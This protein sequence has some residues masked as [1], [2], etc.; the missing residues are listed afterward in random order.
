MSKNKN[1]G[2]RFESALVTL[3]NAYGLNTRRIA[4]G[5]IYDRGD[6]EIK[7]KYGGPGGEPIV[8]LAWKR[9]VN[10]GGGKRMPDGEPVVVVL[11]LHDF[12]SLLGLAEVSAVIE[13]KAAERL[14][15]TRSL[16]KAIVK[17]RQ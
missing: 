10:K 5:G 1:Q 7:G 17:A 16:H 15:V 4:E 13:C 14:N 9:L 12:L 3:A 8:A 2:T 6:V 11:N